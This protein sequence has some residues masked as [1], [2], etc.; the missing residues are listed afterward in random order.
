MAR[1]RLRNYR[2]KCLIDGFEATKKIRTLDIKQPYI[3]ALTANALEKDKQI[4]FEVG[5]DSFLTKPLQAVNL[6]E[7][8]AE[9]LKSV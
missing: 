6:N 3:I 5:M 7:V 4:C 1:L 8:L 9:Y 2:A